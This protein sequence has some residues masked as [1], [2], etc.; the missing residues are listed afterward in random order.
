MVH[1]SEEYRGRVKIVK[2]VAPESR[3]LCGMLRVTGLPTM[4]ALSGGKE[5]SRISGNDLHEGDIRT[6]LESMID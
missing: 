2:V 6:L 5:T 1:L 3:K 4:M